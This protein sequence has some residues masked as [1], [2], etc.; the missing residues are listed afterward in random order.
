MQGIAVPANHRGGKVL[1]V[2]G[3]IVL[4][5][6]AI[7]IALNMGRAAE[8]PDEM[9]QAGNVQDWSANTAKQFLTKD[10]PIQTGWEV[11]DIEEM[12]PE[13]Y[14]SAVSSEYNRPWITNPSG[15]HWVYYFRVV[16]IHSD[17]TKG[18]KDAAVFLEN[19]SSTP[20]WE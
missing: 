15:Y 1:L 11:G 17:G 8:S 20:K 3:G 14:A 4:L 2:A 10:F 9:V 13:Q 7:I 19:G 5:I 6:V 12:T 16:T 18:E